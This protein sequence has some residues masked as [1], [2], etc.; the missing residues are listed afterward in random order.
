MLIINNWEDVVMRDCCLCEL[1]G[2]TNIVVAQQEA[3][4]KKLGLCWMDGGINN[5]TAETTVITIDAKVSPA[6][7]K[8]MIN[9][10]KEIESA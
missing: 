6:H 2:K 10:L 1:R 4:R 7:K 5:N 3:E 9:L 8:R